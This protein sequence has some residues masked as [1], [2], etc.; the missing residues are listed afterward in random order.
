MVTGTIA[1]TLMSGSAI[2]NIPNENILETTET[3]TVTIVPGISGIYSI[4]AG[5]TNTLTV[6]IQDNTSK[7]N[8]VAST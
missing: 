8:K 1:V 7:Y 5:A 3:F 2:V 6:S 4:T